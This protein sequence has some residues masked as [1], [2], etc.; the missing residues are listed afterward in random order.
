M[1][2]I[3]G[4]R[5]DDDI[6]QTGWEREAL[7]RAAA[8]VLLIAGGLLTLATRRRHSTTPN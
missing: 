3:G 2:T 1:G 6:A 8:G 4:L 7:E 5:G